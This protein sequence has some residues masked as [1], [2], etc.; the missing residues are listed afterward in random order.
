MLDRGLKTPYMYKSHPPM[1]RHSFN[2]LADPLVL[3][4]SS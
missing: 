2:L 1:T 3:Y 4:S